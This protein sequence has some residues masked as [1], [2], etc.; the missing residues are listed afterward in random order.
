M[1]IKNLSNL[2]LL[3]A[4]TLASF[5]LTWSS[6]Y[7]DFSTYD[8]IF[9]CAFCAVVVIL[10][11]LVISLLVR[12]SANSFLINLLFASFVL[13]NAYSL[14]LSFI[15]SITSLESYIQLFL[16]AI[17]LFILFTLKEIAD[18]GKF[19]LFV[20]CGVMIV[21]LAGN[22]LLTLKSDI[23][24]QKS[25]SGDDEIAEL[26]LGQASHQITRRVKSVAF[27]EKPNIYIIA[28]DALMPEALLKSLLNLE[29]VPYSIALK[30]NF[31]SFKNMFA[32]VVPTRGSL[33]ALLAFDRDY[34]ANLAIEERSE[35]YSGNV[36]SPLSEIFKHNGYTINTLYAS[37][38]LG[39][40]KGPFIDN[41]F[42]GVPFTVCQFI[43]N[44]IRSIVFMGFCALEETYFWQTQISYWGPMKHLIASFEQQ[45]KSNSPQFFL[46]YIFSPGHTKISF[47]SNN[48]ADIDEYRRL[49]MKNGIE[50]ANMV[51]QLK[52]FIDRSGSR[53][54]LI[55][56]GD[57]GPYLSR[58]LKFQ[59]NPSFYI[60]DRWGIYGGI[61]PRDRCRNYFKEMD[62]IGYG[63]P[64]TVMNN[65]IR[66]ISGGKDPF[67]TPQNSTGPLG[68]PEN[69]TYER[70][71]YE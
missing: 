64:T 11:T 15:T 44:K 26:A 9:I 50:T 42:I 62:M 68:A 47:N 22:T 23:P 20:I 31:H 55:V 13:F 59:D 33:N 28:F 25:H 57:H 36:L 19:Q 54:I 16:G 39:N 60:L 32:D 17:G 48:Q 45:A 4:I 61:Y 51:K 52:E 2:I 3:P 14:H 6:S 30:E 10:Q 12:F 63:T 46:A 65:V 38:Y 24:V 35:L 66:C 67:V 70:L 8:L 1:F 7:R 18:K 56:M 71:K 40:T 41:Y 21:L 5:I 58:T 37:Y 69:I 29:Q 49:H 34:F 53:D 27:E 43:D